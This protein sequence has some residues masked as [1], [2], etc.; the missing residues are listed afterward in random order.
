MNEQ[1]FI[2][3]LKSGS[4]KA[5]GELVEKYQG[6]VTNTC[7]GFVM[8]KDDADDLAQE[9]FVEAHQ[10]LANFREDSKISTWLYRI[11]INKSID[12][13][14]RKTRKKRFAYLT[15]LFGKEDHP[16]PIADHN[17]PNP[18]QQMESE[19]RLAILNSAIDKLP[20]NQAIAFRL[21][22][23]EGLGGKEIAEIMDTSIPSVDALI[24]RAKANLKRQLYSGYSQGK[25]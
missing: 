24:H 5:F 16:L 1:E 15:S 22:K 25:F 2:K 11:A 23:F 9:V 8:N 14:R 17:S 10:G 12:E 19:E 7:Y 6:L 18:H 13:I 4:E 20:G 21:S 3:T